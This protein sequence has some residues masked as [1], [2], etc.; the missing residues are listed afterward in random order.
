MKTIP[1]RI[2]AVLL[3]ILLSFSTLA[4]LPIN[5]QVEDSWTSL[6]S[7][8]EARYGLGVVTENGK[9]YAI[10]GNP[11]GKPTSDINEEYNPQTNTWTNKTRI[12]EPMSD[13][14]IAVYHGKIYCF[15]G[16]T[17][18]TYAYTP[19]Y[20][21]W[22]QKASLPNPR[23][24]IVANTLNDKIYVMGGVLSTLDVYNPLNDSWTTKAPL[25]GGLTAGNGASVVFEGKIH[26]FGAVPREF[27]NQI[28]DPETDTWSKG[29]PLI[30]GYYFTAAGVTTGA[31]APKRIYVFGADKRLWT[32]DT[33][34]LTSQSYD[35]KTGNWT[36]IETIPSGHLMGGVATIDD[37]IYV[38]GGAGAG[39]SQ[40]LYANR[41]CRLY[42]PIEYG[43]SDPTY[44][45][46]PAT[47]TPSPTPTP[48]PNPTPEPEFP[49]T[50]VVASVIILGIVAIG[51]IS[52][53]KKNRKNKI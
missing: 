32:I 46:I 45:P 7:M 35:P 30:D 6:A 15:N 53:Y 23:T 38:I 10:G 5:A 48:T 37:K 18:N 11:E 25:N 52:Y 9:I 8:K 16:E 4:I 31:N 3:V 47:P 19:L 51:I 21:T 44:T 41:L 20:D 43:T 49:T 2:L 39:Y 17:G 36:R 13:F 14:G 42:T 22:E 1:C 28:Y 27:S 33:P 40:T 34:N 24:G 26:V 29:E 12:P 50:I